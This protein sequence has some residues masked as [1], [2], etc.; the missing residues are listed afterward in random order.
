M[1]IDIKNTGFS[2][3]CAAELSNGEWIYKASTSWLPSG[4]YV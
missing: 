2:D 1:R 4:D 3:L